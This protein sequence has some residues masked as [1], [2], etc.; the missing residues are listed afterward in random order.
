MTMTTPPTGSLV[1]LATPFQ[2][3]RLDTD[4]L[5]AFAERQIVRGSTALVVC[6]STGEA[7]SLSAAEYDAAVRA[8]VEVACG[9]V[10]VIAGCAAI[11]TDAAAERAAAAVAAGADG[12][13]CAPP[14]YVKP[15]QDGICAHVRAV[16]HAADRPVM[17]YDVPGRTGVAVADETVARLVERS[18]IVAIKDSTGDLSRPP[19]L[20]ALC[21]A[22]LTQLGGD[23][24]T[25]AAYRAMGGQGCVSVTANV[26]PTLCA[27]M[28]RAWDAGDLIRFAGLRD[29][30]APLHEALFLE[31]NPIPLKAALAMLRLCAPDVR[32]LLTRA[33]RPVRERLAEI[34]FRIAGIEEDAAGR[35][36]P[37][38]AR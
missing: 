36:A 28:H 21:G 13:L 38:L 9:R 19:R 31:S 15:S 23:D 16:A 6:G 37:A 27:R 12:V 18:L 1:A 8:A 10:P 24:G 17:L 2:D 3:R 35:P 5:A 7:T 22:A 4:T 25:A 29:L 14:P 30:L 32:L 34:L 11:S 20:H 33:G 26:T